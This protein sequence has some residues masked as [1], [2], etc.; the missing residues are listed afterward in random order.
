MPSRLYT[1]NDPLFSEYVFNCMANSSAAVR[2]ELEPAELKHFASQKRMRQF[3]DNETLERR[4]TLLERLGF[5]FVLC[6]G[7]EDYPVDEALEEALDT[8]SDKKDRFNFVRKMAPD[9]FFCFGSR[10]FALAAQLAAQNSHLQAYILNRRYVEL[11]H[12]LVEADLTTNAQNQKDAQHAFDALSGIILGAIDDPELVKSASG[13]TQDEMQVLL[14]LYKHRNTFLPVD[15]IALRLGVGVRSDITS[16]KCGYLE[17]G[18][19]VI[20][21]PNSKGHAGKRSSHFTISEKGIN[22]VMNYLKYLIRQ[23]DKF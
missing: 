7:P 5:S 23:A 14:A 1:I 22:A 9:Q 4:L 18:K 20:R 2:Q 21:R 17:K 16:R 15:Q 8:I 11:H 19:Y 13:V 10:E 12:E 6:V 3:A